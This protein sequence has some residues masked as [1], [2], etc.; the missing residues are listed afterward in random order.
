VVVAEEVEE[1]V[2]EQ[3]GDLLFDGVAEGIGLIEGAGD[4]DGHFA[5][6]AGRVRGGKTE[7]VGGGVLA[8]E[9][10]IQLAQV[11]VG[12]QQ[13]GEGGAAGD[14]DLEAEGK[15]AEPGP[16]KPGHPGLEQK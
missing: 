2:E 11:P 15:I 4:A 14:F 5:K 8:E 13:G 12:G 9:V 7:D 10:A 3:D 16:V 6:A 1:A